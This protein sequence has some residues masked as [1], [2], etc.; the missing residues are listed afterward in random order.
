MERYFV[1]VLSL[2]LFVTTTTVAS[3]AMAQ[4]GAELATRHELLDQARE[5]SAQGDHTR[6]L[7]L[8]TRA[9][10]IR[11]TASVRYFITEEQ[12]ALSLTTDAL[13]S[14]ELCLQEASREP[15]S[16]NRDAVVA[17]C[18]RLVDA[19]HDRIG[20]VVVLLPGVPPNATVMVGGQSLPMPLWGVPFIVIAGR[21]MIDVTA[22]GFLPSH[23]EVLVPPRQTIN[24]EIRLSPRVAPFI[25]HSPVEH[26]V[27]QIPIPNVAFTPHAPPVVPLS[28]T[29]RSPFGIVVGS[30]GLVGLGV[31]IASA[32][33]ANGLYDDFR[34]SCV[35]QS[36]CP[37]RD[38]A[39]TNVHTFDTIANAS[40]IGGG[41][42][43]ATGAV[44]YLAIRHTETLPSTMPRVAMDP[45][46]RTMTA[47]WTF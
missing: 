33:Q 17:N 47:G 23:H 9:G 6:A 34:A 30:I 42:L 35:S 22:D 19:L 16:R 26:P 27:P 31:G 25:V 14:A 4:T 41:V 2:M 21:V 44:L 7:D 45:I 40:F 1:R 13:A 37:N 5:M 15:P 20:S 36:R 24:V 12:S 28:R 11:M 43:L 46:A 8:A 39:P 29:V 3:Q 18:Q 38:S 10:Q 32:L